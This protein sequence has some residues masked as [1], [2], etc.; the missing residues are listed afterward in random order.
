MVKAWK[1]K[2]S[3]KSIDL[4]EIR[5]Y[6]LEEISKIFI[7]MFDKFKHKE[8]QLLY[9]AFFQK[10]HLHI[11]WKQKPSSNFLLYTTHMLP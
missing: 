5:M 7:K 10:D 8:T 4:I 6:Q 2:Y 9:N 3:N 11:D 1:A